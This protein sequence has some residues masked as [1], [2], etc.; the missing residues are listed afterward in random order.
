[1]GA[2]KL[3]ISD[4]SSTGYDGYTVKSGKPHLQE[5]ALSDL[6]QIWY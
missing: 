3:V 2:T 4:A 1:M 6:F 5:G